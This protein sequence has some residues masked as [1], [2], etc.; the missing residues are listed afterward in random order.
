MCIK[1]YKTKKSI[2]KNIQ[3]RSFENYNNCENSNNIIIITIKNN[4][5]L[6]SVFLIYVH[7]EDTFIFAY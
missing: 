2:Y 4:V 1:N 7:V 3:N 5:F 6:E